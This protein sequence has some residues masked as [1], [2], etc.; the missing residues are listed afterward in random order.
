MQTPKVLFDARWILTNGQIDGISR[1]SE[2]LAKAMAKKDGLELGWLIHDKRQLALLPNK[3]YLLVNRPT[4]ALK[5]LFTLG[6]KINQSG[7]DI[8]YSPFF[9]IGALGIKLKFIL[10]IHD[11]IYYQYRTPPQ[12]LPWIVRVVWRL[13][14][15]NYWLMR[16]QLNRTNVVATV[17]QT[18]KQDLLKVRATKKPII[19]VSN[20]ASGNFTAPTNPRRHSSNS[21]VYM[22]AF[23]PYKNVE[24]LIDALEFLPGMTLHLC[25]K[26][27]PA[28]RKMLQKIIDSKNL[29]NRVKFHNGVKDEQYKQLLGQARCAVSASKAEGFGLPMI[30]AQQ[31]GV[32]FVAAST[33]IF[34]EIGGSS[35][36]FFNPL[37]PQA[38]AKQILKLGDK[39]TNFKYSKLGVNNAA[40]FTW[41][42]SASV[43][44][45][46]CRKVSKKV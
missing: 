44:M 11:M 3:P 15:A 10:T 8:L 32:P 1:Y 17:S 19:T 41:E 42:Q 45:E 43:A 18:A 2:E 35:V 38:C 22:G 39:K 37:N 34:K 21:I 20:A 6:K 24:C 33:P 14:H 28:R 36:L 4:S 5:E 16:W 9:I 31:A 26:V 23:T 40:R 29:T 7:Y 27:P 30:E 46:I 25:S 12:W 13:Y